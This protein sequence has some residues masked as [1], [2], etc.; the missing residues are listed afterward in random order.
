MK[1]KIT[2]PKIEILFE[3]LADELPDPATL[4]VSEET[5]EFITTTCDSDKPAD[6]EANKDGLVV[7]DV[8]TLTSGE[9]DLSLSTATIPGPAIA[10]DSYG[11]GWDARIHSAAKT[12]I[13]NGRWK[14]KRGVDKNYV[15]KVVGEQREKILKDLPNAFLPEAPT[16]LEDSTDIW[17]A[18]PDINQELA[19]DSV[20][21]D[22]PSRRV[23]GI[24]TFEDLA[25]RVNDLISKGKITVLEV[26]K[27]IS[28]KT[29]GGG[30]QSLTTRQDLIPW[31]WEAISAA[32]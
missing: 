10:L 3:V 6:L 15:E 13:A 26:Q 2:I 18:V 7:S 19:P 32:L 30:F 11:T 25:N 21:Q 4:P 22:D 20:P 27:I 31:V 9:I 12:K 28:E 24:I 14:L 23:T 16:V 1:Y 29:G 5:A 17:H 8:E